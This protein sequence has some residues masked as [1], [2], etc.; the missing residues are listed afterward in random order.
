MDTEEYD[1]NED[2]R[3]YDEYGNVVPSEGEITK[4]TIERE[5]EQHKVN[6]SQKRRTKSKGKIDGKESLLTILF[7]S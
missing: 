3:I 5:R 7:C 4:K 1:S 2:S 6:T